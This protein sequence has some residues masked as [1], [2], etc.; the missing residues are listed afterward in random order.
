MS[1]TFDTATFLI[2][3]KSE[4]FFFFGRGYSVPPLT[5]LLYVEDFSLVGKEC[6]GEY[7]PCFFE[8]RGFVKVSLAVVAQ[9]QLG[10]D[11]GDASP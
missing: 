3:I 5:L 11:F 7:F 8:Q 4:S 2:L 6:I 9:Q 1:V 10:P